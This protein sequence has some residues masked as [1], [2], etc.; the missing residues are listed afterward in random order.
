MSLT[1]LYDGLRFPE[2]ARWHDGRLWFSDMHTGEIFRAFP[3]S[4]ELPEV[5]TTIDD[6]PSGLAWLPDGT[7]LISSMLKRVVLRDD[8]KGD[9]SVYADLSGLTDAPINDMVMDTTGTLYLGGFGYDLYAD[10]PMQQGPVFA[11]TG[12]GEASVVESDMTFP[13]GSVILPA[14][15]TLVVAE[16]W[17]A[18]L[19]AFDI[20]PDGSLGNKR[21]WAELPEGST[22]DG[23]AVDA[24]G[25][26][27]VSCITNERYLRVVAGGEVTDV[28]DVPG[29]C[30]ADCVL[31][32]PDGRS[33]FLVT[34]NSW[35]PAETEIRDGRVEVV[36]VKVPGPPG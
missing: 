15:R 4:D 21:V 18:R 32:G 20:N 33:L 31:G 27:W 22:P 36:Q 2:G 3:D 19:T 29:R 5:V 30:P 34:S 24:E 35:M 17:G 6:Q 26:V 13:N 25:G 10:A 12:P 1:T 16:T 8:L 9:Q 14:T 28:V 23:L 7:L 11:I